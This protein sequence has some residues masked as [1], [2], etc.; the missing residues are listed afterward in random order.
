MPWPGVG[1]ADIIDSINSG[2]KLERPAG[3]PLSCY[4]LML[5][6]WH[7]SPAERPTAAELLKMMDHLDEGEMSQP[8]TDGAALP[9]NN[10]DSSQGAAGCISARHDCASHP[11]TGRQARLSKPRTPEPEPEPDVEPDV[12]PNVAQ[13]YVSDHALA[14]RTMPAP[15]RMPAMLDMHMHMHMG[16]GVGS[17][18]RAV[19]RPYMR[20]GPGASPFIP[21]APPPFMIAGPAA[22]LRRPPMAGMMRMPAPM[23]MMPRPLNAWAAAPNNRYAM[24][25]CP[26]PGCPLH[27]T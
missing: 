10:S 19:P 23:M 26:N 27:G 9:R 4:D 17:G 8:P 2:A 25:C 13:R 21:G 6:C 18:P 5:A 16:V 12:E 22:T 14:A 1:D 11:A 20:A 3:V 7:V 24:C 15:M